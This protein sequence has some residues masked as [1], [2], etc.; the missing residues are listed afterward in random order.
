MTKTTT[1]REAAQLLVEIDDLLTAPIVPGSGAAVMGKPLEG[2]LSI[3]GPVQPWNVQAA[4]SL[5]LRYLCQDMKKLTRW[6]RALPADARDQIVFEV[7]RLRLEREPPLAQLERAVEAFEAAIA[8]AEYRM[9][10][11]EEEVLARDVA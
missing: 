9:D 4:A 11:L 10:C 6:W 3:Y 1:P 7:R 5:Q 8:R 2:P